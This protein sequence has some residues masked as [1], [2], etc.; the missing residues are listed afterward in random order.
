MARK[1]FTLIELLVVIAI[2]AILAALLLPALEIARESAETTKCVAN[3]RSISLGVEM[4]VGAN[5]DLLPRNN[6]APAGTTWGVGTESGCDP[7]PGYEASGPMPGQNSHMGWWAN[8]VYEFM[9]VAETYWCDAFA[10]SE[11]WDSGAVDTNGELFF[12][13]PSGYGYPIHCAFSPMAGL[14]GVRSIRRK[15]DILNLGGT[16]GDVWLYGHPEPGWCGYTNLYTNTLY[17]G[18]WPGYHNRS[19]GELCYDGDS[20]KITFN[21]GTNGYIFGDGH[22]EPM[23]WMDARCKTDCMNGV[24]MWIDEGAS[25]AEGCTM[26][27]STQGISSWCDCTAANGQKYPNGY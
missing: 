13:A 19:R 15:T 9:P 11:A 24:V 27:T 20:A 26:R 12:S 17:P 16:L 4:Y 25:P 10:Q 21:C 23:T 22:A 14:S 6:L 18:Y 5:N 3:M 1:A 7:A 2:I 8:K